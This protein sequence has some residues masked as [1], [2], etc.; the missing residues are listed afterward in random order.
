MGV[1]LFLALAEAAVAQPAVKPVKPAVQAD[2]TPLN[3]PQP[4]GAVRP[5]MDQITLPAAPAA[6]S[7]TAMNQ[8]PADLRMAE[9][10][11][12]TPENAVVG[13]GRSPEQ[14]LYNQ[15]ARVWT[16]IRQR[17]QQPTPELIAREIGPDQ[18]TKFLGQVPDAG[19]IFGVDS[20][21]LPIPKPG[22]EQIPLGAG[23]VILPAQGS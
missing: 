3:V 16:T 13:E 21:T 19:K 20:D 5:S 11:K 12:D 23:I 14:D 17:G 4:G 10:V 7:R 18:L 8:I 22:R 1:L 2:T 6:Q 15:V 9:A